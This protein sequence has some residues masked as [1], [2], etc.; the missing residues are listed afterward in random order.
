MQVGKPKPLEIATPARASYE[1]PCQG[2]ETK[3]R[4][5]NSASVTTAPKWDGQFERNLELRE[6]PTIPEVVRYL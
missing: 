1:I 3:E 2:K 5:D 4:E 6:I